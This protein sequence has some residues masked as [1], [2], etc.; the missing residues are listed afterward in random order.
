MQAGQQIDPTLDCIDRNLNFPRQAGVHQLLCAAFGQQLHQ[1][2]H[3]SQIA[4]MCDL[5]QVFARELLLTQ[6]APPA[7]KPAVAA[8]KRFGESSVLPQ[9][10]P[11]CGS[12]LGGRSNFVSGQLRPQAFADAP[13]MHAVEQVAS[14]QAV[15]ATTENVEPGASSYDQTNPLAIAV[16][17]ALQQALPFAVL[18]QVVQHGNGDLCCKAVQLESFGQRGR[19]PQQPPA[20]IS[21]VPVEITVADRPAGRSLAD[22]ARSGDQRHLAMPAQM[23]GQHLGIKTVSFLHGTIIS[24]IVKWSKPFYDNRETIPTI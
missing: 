11:V 21:V 6:G 22:L 13:R 8:E 17:E 16:E 4:H 3:R 10:V 23:I 9:R 19:T 2:F 5:A 24:R 14:H 15:T 12:N 1:R 20:I 18:V 7:R